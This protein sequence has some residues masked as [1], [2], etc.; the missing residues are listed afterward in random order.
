M[1]KKQTD[2]I[3]IREQLELNIHLAG[4]S[5]CRLFERQSVVI[6]KLIENLLHEPQRN[7][8]KLDDR[9]KREMHNLIAGKLTSG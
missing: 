5:A 1:E 2:G 9:F 8:F 4:C 7:A 6:D 3:T